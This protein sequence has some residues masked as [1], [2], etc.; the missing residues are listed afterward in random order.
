MRRRYTRARV[1]AYA[2]PQDQRRANTPVIAAVAGLLT[3]IAIYAVA[4]LVF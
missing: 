3:S 2:I 4:S 1:I